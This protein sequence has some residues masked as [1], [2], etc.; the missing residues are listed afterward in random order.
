[1]TQTWLL[2]IIFFPG[3]QASKMDKR[4]AQVAQDEVRMWPLLSVWKLLSLQTD[5]SL[6]I[7]LSRSLYRSLFLLAVCLSLSFSLTVLPCLSRS[8]KYRLSAH[9]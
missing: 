1:M 9:Q 8:L 3:F 6:Q 5:V 2:I 4:A 7:S